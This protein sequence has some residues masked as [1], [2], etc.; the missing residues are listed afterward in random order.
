MKWNFRKLSCSALLAFAIAALPVL[1]HADGIDPPTVTS[2]SSG[3]FISGTI[4]GTPAAGNAVT[5]SII[6]SLAS[7][8]IDTGTLTPTII[9]GL[10]QFTGG[11][12]T[13]T[14]SQGTITEGLTFGTLQSDLIASFAI[15]AGLQPSSTLIDG[16]TSMSWTIT[17]GNIVAGGAGIN[18]TNQTTPTVPEPSTL[19]LFGTG[20]IG[21][22]TGVIRRKLN[23]GKVTRILV[24]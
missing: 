7:F 22:V 11:T 2:I 12:V 6:G 3:N 19:A 1:S 18:F 13:V 9:P 16:S 17:N 15:G 14:N 20:L 8:T 21:M 4:T 23:V 5:V 24:P 10:F